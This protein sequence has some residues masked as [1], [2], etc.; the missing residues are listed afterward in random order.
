MSSLLNIQLYLAVPPQSQLCYVSAV[1]AGEVR[2]LIAC[3][4][5]M[6]YGRVESRKWERNFRLNYV[7]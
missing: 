3:G 2:N 6:G 5:G 4:K 7:A 1:R